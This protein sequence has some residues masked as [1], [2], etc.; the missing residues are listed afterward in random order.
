[1][2]R[3]VAIVFFDR[4]RNNLAYGFYNGRPVYQ[5]RDYE[6]T[7][8]PNSLWACALEPSGLS[9]VYFAIP[10]REATLADIMGLDN[11]N[12]KSVAEFLIREHSEAVGEILEKS[13]RIANSSV[14]AEPD[15]G[16]VRYMGNDVLESSRFV[17]GY[18]DVCVSPD[19]STLMVIPRNSGR[20]PCIGQRIVSEGLDQ[21][22]HSKNGENLDVED[23]GGFLIISMKGVAD[24]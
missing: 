7:I 3:E 5:H 2:S 15:D 23:H 19:N 9:N 17:D 14:N 20:I 4:M 13:G 11:A 8:G 24:A 21:I 22:L 18:Y 10:V 1:M 16:S 6:G 12:A